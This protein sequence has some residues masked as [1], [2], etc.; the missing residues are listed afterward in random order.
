MLVNL[1]Q[2]N[3]CIIDH[4]LNFLFKCFSIGQKKICK[5]CY[6]RSNEIRILSFEIQYGFRRTSDYPT[7][8][9]ATRDLATYNG[10]QV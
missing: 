8:V 4:R 6:H 10:S 5:I 9:Q 3:K 1:T 7:K 2:L